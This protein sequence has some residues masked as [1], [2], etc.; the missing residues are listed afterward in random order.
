MNSSKLLEY[1]CIFL[2]IVNVHTS[3]IFCIRFTMRPVSDYSLNLKTGLD[4]EN[5]IISLRLSITVL[6][7][8]LVL[9]AFGLVLNVNF[10][11]TSEVK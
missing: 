5:C 11:I 3:P 8:V 7:L 1:A 10:S 2:S 9:T 6:V 4:P